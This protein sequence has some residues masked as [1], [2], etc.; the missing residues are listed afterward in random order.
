[1]IDWDDVDF[2]SIAWP[3]VWVGSAVIFLCALGFFIVEACSNERECSQR[4]CP[5]GQQPRLLSGDC[6]CVSRAQ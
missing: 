3:M 2:V 6:L 4:S 5:S 1:M